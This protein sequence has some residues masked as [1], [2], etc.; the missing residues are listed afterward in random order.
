[1]NIIKAHLP[2][3]C[4]SKNLMRSVDGAA[5]HFISAKNILPEDPFN[6]D[7]IIGILK[8]YKLSAHYL[9][10][11]DGTVIELVPDF[12][13]AYHAGKSIMNGRKSCNNFTIG[14]ELVG[15][16][17]YPYTDEQI[18]NLGQLLAQLMTEHVFNSD[19][20]QGHDEIR[21]NWN[22]EY[23]DKKASVKVDPGKHF[24]WEILKDMIASVSM[25]IKHEQNIG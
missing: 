19:W 2:A 17:D 5:V 14:I 4:Y 10:E 22:R 18:L 25:Q 6:R 11:R 16:T 1:M 9:I 12:H 20:V 23:P 15:G 8:E 24:P 7:A 21:A 3:D 13:K